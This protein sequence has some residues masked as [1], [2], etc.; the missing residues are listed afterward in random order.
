LSDLVAAVLAGGEGRR[1]RP[2][3][4]LIPKPMVPVGSEERPLL[5]Y[6]VW[7]LARHGVRDLVF[8]VG[9]RWRQV[10]AYFR[11]GS[12]WGVRIR[13]S[14]DD[15]RYSNTGGAL[16]KAWKLGL[17]GSDV[18]L[19]WYGDILA[20]LDVGALL[21][22]HRK[23]GAR[24]TLAVARGYRVP[25]GVAR[26]EDGRVVELVEK[27]ML[28]IYATIGILALDPS[29]LG[30]AGEALGSSFDVMGDLI[31]WMIGRG[32]RVQAYI[33]E[34]PWYDVGSMERYA[35]L[36]EAGLGEFLKAPPLKVESH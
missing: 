31:P 4:E 27:P 9:Y 30:E 8:L 1:F 23:S 7:W 16:L 36:D 20:P 14:V 12:Q 10:A 26:V 2:Y 28:P 17:L 25:V 24:A 22:T 3:T 33:H 18:V 5:E 19:V 11:D 34:G 32:M 21:S 35:K 15:E 13:Y 29:V 6:I